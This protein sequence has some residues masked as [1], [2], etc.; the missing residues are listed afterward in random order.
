M[1]EFNDMKEYM[2]DLIDCLNTFQRHPPCNYKYCKR[3]RNGKVICRFGFPI[4]LIPV[5]RLEKI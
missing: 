3:V 5:S 2:T 1:Y 4:K